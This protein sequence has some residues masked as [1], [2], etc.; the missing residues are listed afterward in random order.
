MN[1]EKKIYIIMYAGWIAFILALCFMFGRG[2]VSD[3]QDGTE[4]IEYELDT[5]YGYQQSAQADI[6]RAERFA[7]ASQVR[8]DG[9]ADSTNRLQK[10]VDECEALISECQQIIR[11]VQ[12]RGSTEAKKN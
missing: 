4:H 3:K 11:T 10:G 1:D 7:Q 12:A 2:D 8:L 5:A 6:E 9:I